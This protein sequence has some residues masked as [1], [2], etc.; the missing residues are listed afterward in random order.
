[1]RLFKSLNLEDHPYD[2]LR[3]KQIVGS[4]NFSIFHDT[5]YDDEYPDEWTV[6]SLAQD[7]GDWLG[8]TLINGLKGHF[9]ST[10]YSQTWL[11]STSRVE[12]LLST[13]LPKRLCRM[14]R[15]LVQTTSLIHNWGS[16]A[17]LPQLTSTQLH[18]LQAFSGSEVLRG[19][20]ATLRRVNQSNTSPDKIKGLFLL[21]F[22]TLVAVGYVPAKVRI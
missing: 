21:L 1:M 22:G 7:S 5:F 19:L 10:S 18:D 14:V 2:L 4:P 6:E 12:S 16:S 11:F 9:Q 3:L 15:Y 8:H 13:M 17:S 20:E